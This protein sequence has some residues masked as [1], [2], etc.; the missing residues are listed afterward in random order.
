MIER[1]IVDIV[2]NY[3]ID[4][5]VYKKDQRISPDDDLSSIGLESVDI[6]SIIAIIENKYSVI[7][8]ELDSIFE[9]KTIKDLAN[10]LK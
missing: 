1:E 9:C 7:L 6:V 10:L 8:F 4:V 3:L 5:G 2:N